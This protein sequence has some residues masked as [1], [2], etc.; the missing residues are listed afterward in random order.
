MIFEK[1]GFTIVDNKTA[2]AIQGQI[3]LGINYA[4]NKQYLIFL[5]LLPTVFKIKIVE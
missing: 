4:L 3:A 5:K 2:N 1:M